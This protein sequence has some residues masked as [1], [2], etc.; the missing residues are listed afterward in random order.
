MADKKSKK[1]KKKK[2]PKKSKLNLQEGVNVWGD[3]AFIL[4]NA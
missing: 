1:K 3:G 4:N 2:G